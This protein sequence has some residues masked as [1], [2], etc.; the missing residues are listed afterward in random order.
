MASVFKRNGKGAY[1]AK[2][3]DHDGKR[4]EKST[5]TTDF[6]TAERL[7]G[8]WEADALLRREG[9]IDPRADRWSQHEASP[10]V[11]HI[12]EF[13]DSLRSANVS[14]A[15]VK[16][17]KARLCRLSKNVKADRISDLTPARVLAALD[18]I[19]KAGASLSTLNG[20]VA[21][22][23]QFAG[24][25]VREGRTATNP[26]AHLSGYNAETERKR[27]R[28]DL[29][30][31]EV[32]RVV[33]ASQ[34]HPTVKIPKRYRDEK[35]VLRTSM[36]AMH[37]PERAWAYRLACETGFRIGEV[38]TLTPDS[39][40]FTANPPL[41]LLAACDSKNRKAVG[42]PIRPEFA[43]EL[44]PWLA[45]KPKGKALGLMPEKKAAA[46]LAAD[47]AH[48]REKWIGEATD[49]TERARREES[50][51]LRYVDSR[52]RYAD[53]HALRVT[54]VSRVLDAG[55]SVSE[56]MALARH[57][58]PRL[59]TRTYARVGLHSLSR[60]LGDLPQWDGA[61]QAPNTD[62][63]RM[64]ATGTDGRIGDDKP[65]HQPHQSQR[66]AELRSAHRRD[67]DSDHGS[68]GGVRKR[69]ESHAL[70]IAGD[71]GASQCEKSHLGD[72]NP[73]PMLY[74]SIALPLS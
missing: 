30:P 58:D 34:A 49:P 66:K 9:V 12:G 26:I 43:D 37:Y 52:D 31:E 63:T 74:E 53:F 38:S 29:S 10:L 71:D 1:I 14:E 20:Y 70:R 69:L 40:D 25:L 41:V 46:M 22:V 35:K 2:W 16:S 67:E 7:A 56:A 60:V 4:K 15:R 5:R 21:I 65:H 61:I 36:I 8:K 3:Y 32:A 45:T 18:M 33:A 19:R 24:W 23:K 47:L 57:S 44:R 17:A 50:D 39:F 51:M 6:R 68:E 59:T 13:V 27:V 62:Q 28:R 73:G 55:A 11:E 42:Q 48:A 72:L 54:F 64:Q